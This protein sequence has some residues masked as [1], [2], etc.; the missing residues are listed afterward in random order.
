MQGEGSHRTDL[1][2]GGNLENPLRILPFPLT[3]L[4]FFPFEISEVLR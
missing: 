2:E 3:I 4:T 1:P